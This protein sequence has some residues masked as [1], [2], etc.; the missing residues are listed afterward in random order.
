MTGQSWTMLAV[1]M[2]LLLAMAY[3]LAAYLEKI[4]SK[5]T[6]PVP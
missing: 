4:F 6:C 1:F 2:A 3:P 5:S